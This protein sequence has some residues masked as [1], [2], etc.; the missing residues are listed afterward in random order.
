MV[1]LARERVKGK[2]VSVVC[3]Q[4]TKKKREKTTHHHHNTNNNQ[5][6]Q[7]TKKHEGRVILK[8][9]DPDDDGDRQI[10]DDILPYL[11]LISHALTIFG[12]AKKISPK[13]RACC[14]RDENSLA[15]IFRTSYRAS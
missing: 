15:T 7:Q 8:K 13:F 10:D 6:D 4:V 12:A 1:S 2:R 5:P 3:H 9:G 11:L 14:Y